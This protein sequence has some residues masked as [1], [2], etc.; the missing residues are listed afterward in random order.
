MKGKNVSQQTFVL[1]LVVLL[2]AGCGGAPA[3]PAATPTPVPPTATPTPV[4]LIAK[5]GKWSGQGVSFEVAP[6]GKIAV[7]NFTA[8]YIS[9]GSLNA[10][11]LYASDIA[12]NPDGT[13]GFKSDKTNVIGEFNSPTTASFTYEI[14]K[15]L[16]GQAVSG[17]ETAAVEWTS[18]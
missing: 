17:A 2:L 12:V 4:P 11:Y 13:F 3:Q 9:G 6:D 7:L 16:Q 8:H 1:M 14:Y 5:P 18:P 10:E 15:G